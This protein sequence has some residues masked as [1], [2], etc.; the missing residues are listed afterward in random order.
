MIK[1]SI[2]NFSMINWYGLSSIYNTS[3]STKSNE[4]NSLE[5]IKGNERL[6]CKL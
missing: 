2:K 1:A 3:R 5:E 6:K 4:I